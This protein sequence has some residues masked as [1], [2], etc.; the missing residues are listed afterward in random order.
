MAYQRPELADLRDEA[1]ADIDRILGADARLQAGNLNVLAHTVAGAADSLH[2]HLEWL[3]KQILPDTAEAEYL[4]R[5]AA[6]RKMY[7][8]EP[9]AAEGFCVLSG[10]PGLVVQ[11]NQQLVRSDGRIYSVTKDVTFAAATALVPVTADL[12]GAAG[13][14][15]SGTTLTLVT[16]VPGV[17]SAAI[18]GS[19]GLVKGTDKESVESLRQ[20]LLARLRNPPSGGATVDYE[21]WA[22]DVSGVTRAWPS[23]LELGA[24]TVTVRFVCDDEE[25]P[26]PTPEKV[27]EVQEYLDFVGPVTAEKF[28]VAPEAAPINFHIQLL[29]DSSA[30]RN[31][32]TAELRDLI[33]R[34]A[35]PS[36]TILISRIREAVSV[37]AGEEDHILLSPTANI[38]QAVGKMATLGVI[39]WE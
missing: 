22:L 2:G 12:V 26:I 36:K 17:A 5:H 29:P 18:V 33:R 34:D 35:A 11:L 38:V 15:Q 39:T 25:D 10:A 31:A 9:T 27:A 20:R 4:L 14:A 16:P 23:P 30:I 28:A 3:S 37:A 13:N 32:V 19:A 24:G 8:R 7:L 21:T 1:F 6:I